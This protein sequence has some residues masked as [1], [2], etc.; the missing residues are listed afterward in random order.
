MAQI[1]KKGR[2]DNRGGHP[3]CGRKK[4]DKKSFHVRCKQTSIT[5][6]RKYVKYININIMDNKIKDSSIDKYLM[7]D[8]I[9]DLRYELI[10]SMVEKSANRIDEILIEALKVKGFEFEDKSSL[11]NFL[12]TKCKSISNVEE[13]TI[14]LYVDETPFLMYDFNPIIEPV[15]MENNSIT[16]RST[17][18]GYKFL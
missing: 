17:F 15:D 16:F 12:K 9:S 5:N 18:A 2:K 13:K 7:N 10:G 14:T 6:I 11:E 8:K 1:L 3:N 4:G